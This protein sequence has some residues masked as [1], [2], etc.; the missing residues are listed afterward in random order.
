[1]W[2]ALVWGYFFGWFADTFTKAGVPAFWP[3]QARLVIPGNPKLRLYTDSPEELIF[4]TATSVVLVIC[5]NIYSQ[6]G[7]LRSFNQWTGIPSGAIEIANSEIDQYRLIA[8]VEGYNTLTL[9]QVDEEFEIVKA[10]TASDLLLL[11]DDGSIYRAGSSQEAQIRLSRVH[12]KRQ[13][14][15]LQTIRELKYEDESFRLPSDLTQ[16]SYITGLLQVDDVDQVV[17]TPRVWAFNTVRVQPLGEGLGMVHL[18][19][20]RVQDLQPL[21][22]SFVT[23]QLIIREV[24]HVHPRGSPERD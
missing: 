6:G 9:E 21:N 13:E 7:I 2:L 22:N 14:Q 10:L 19:S 18:E 24:N 16:R 8:E 15:I 5:L 20:A 1:L 12:V 23:G 17:V 4:L 11:A 3:H